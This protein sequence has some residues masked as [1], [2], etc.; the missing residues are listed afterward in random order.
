[1]DKQRSNTVAVDVDL[2]SRGHLKEAAG[3]V[4]A[5]AAVYYYY[6]SPASPAKDGDESGED[7][8]LLWTIVWLATRL[9][10][11]AAVLVL[12]LLLALVFNQ[13]RILYVPVPPSCE[14]NPSDHMHPDRRQIPYEEVTIETEDNVKIHGWF[15]YQRDPE[16]VP[17]TVLYFHG[18]AGNIGF[19]IDN[20]QQM[21]T[22]LKYNILIIDYRGYGKSEDGGGPC[23]DGFLKDAKASYRWIVDRIRHPKSE[24]KVKMSL[25]RIL[26]FGRS[27]GGAVAL[28][29]G[30]Q[31]LQERLDDE[32]LN[33]PLQPLPVGF[34]LENTFTN[35]REMA[36][37][38]FGFLKFLRPLLR[39]PLV[40]DEWKGDEALKFIAENH[41][42]WCLCLL[43]GRV[44]QIVPPQQ[45]DAMHDIVRE[46][47]PQVL[48]FEMFPDGNH[49]DTPIRGGARYWSAMKSFMEEVKN[50]E[51]DRTLCN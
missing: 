15:L 24:E 27:I 25:D 40:L 36:I 22:Q 38:L 12:L 4:I 7:L 29:L 2:E 34:I 9:F 16:E 26:F 45:M 6:T 33:K 44:D 5:A 37:Q 14:R 28:R 43:S 19:R 31:L 30:A 39:Y 42:H 8:W 11:L 13:R 20:L 47:S 23:E 41:K 17:Y 46:R 21:Y 32:K 1:M 18:N 48:R 10:Q 35:L 51:K 50:T 49:N 3:L